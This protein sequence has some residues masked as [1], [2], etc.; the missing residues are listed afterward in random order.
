MGIM[1]SI[2]TII[3][4]LQDVKQIN[5]NMQRAERVGSPDWHK[6]E[7]IDDRLHEVLAALGQ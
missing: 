1:T 4:K 7:S 5:D 3:K 2:D 6:H